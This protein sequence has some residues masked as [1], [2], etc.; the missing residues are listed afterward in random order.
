MHNS[1]NNEI[2]YKDS[3]LE[4][5]NDRIIFYNYYFPSLKSKEVPVRDIDKVEVKAPSIRTGKYR[6]HG[7]GDFRIWY[8]LDAGRS[9]RDKIFVLSL[10]TQRIRIGF[11]TEN[12]AAVE[13]YFKEKGLLS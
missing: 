5:S 9:G 10:R 3:L 1:M 4:I 8:P 2:I 13:T 12:S 11:T 6:Y 7:T